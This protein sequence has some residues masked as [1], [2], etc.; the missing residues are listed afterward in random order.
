MECA[1]ATV[2]QTG[3]KYSSKVRRP[4]KDWTTRR[5]IR[6]N[7]KS[8]GGVGPD[9]LAMAREPNVSPFADDGVQ[10]KRA[11]TSVKTMPTDGWMRKR[12]PTRFVENNKHTEAT[13]RTGLQLMDRSTPKLQ[14]N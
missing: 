14:K 9:Y 7:P 12:D 1:S 4:S 8:G 2:I 13:S 6:N 10:A 5:P 11:M 3:R